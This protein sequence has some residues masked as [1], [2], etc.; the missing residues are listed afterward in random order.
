VTGVKN[1]ERFARAALQNYQNEKRKME[2]GLTKLPKSIM[3]QFCCLSR[4]VTR[5]LIGGGVYSYIRVLPDEFLLNYFVF[6]IIS[7]EIRR[8]EHEYM[9]IHPPPN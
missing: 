6:K 9:N 3:K 5:A 7:K 2:N 8:A 4:G 1:N